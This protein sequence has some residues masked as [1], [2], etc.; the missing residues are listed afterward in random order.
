M[1]VRFDDRGLFWGQRQ[2]QGRP[3]IWSEPFQL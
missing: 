2:I 3:A 1:E